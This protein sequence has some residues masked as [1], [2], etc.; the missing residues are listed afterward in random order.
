MDQ[1]PLLSSQKS[2]HIQT[3]LASTIPA[4]GSSSP[5]GIPYSPVNITQPRQNTFSA[6]GFALAPG[7]EI[8]YRMTQS[9][10]AQPRI[11]LSPQ[12]KSSDSVVPPDS[13]KFYSSAPSGRYTGPLGQPPAAC[14]PAALGMP[15]ARQ[16]P[17]RMLPPGEFPPVP[18]Q[19]LLASPADLKVQEIHEK[20]DRL[21]RTLVQDIKCSVGK[22]RSEFVDGLKSKV[23]TIVAEAKSLD[24]KEQMTILMRVA[25]LWQESEWFEPARYYLLACSGM[26]NNADNKQFQDISKFIQ[27]HT[28]L[29]LPG[30]PLYNQPIIVKDHFIQEINTIKFHA[31]ILLA[32]NNGKL[33][34]KAQESKENK[35]SDKVETKTALDPATSKF[36]PEHFYGLLGK[37]L[38]SINTVNANYFVNLSPFF[39]SKL[40]EAKRIQ[41]NYRAEYL[42]H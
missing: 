30:E 23:K 36:K 39:N 24:I 27:K 14:P 34:L 7:T 25:I 28:T 31:M 17:Q 13:V 3:D 41:F 1:K 11:A 22:R 2:L 6:S 12:Q 15:S 32:W 33:F 19:S 35:S 26:H 4:A 10:P 9:Y 8:R 18:Q 20:L 37:V 29:L 21:V 42:Q 40:D 16:P 38:A 5:H